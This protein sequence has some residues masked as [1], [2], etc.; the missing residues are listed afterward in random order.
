MKSRKKFKILI[1]T[2]AILMLLAFVKKNH[3]P[4]SNF[5]S[6]KIGSSD[7]YISLPYDLKP[8]SVNLPDETKEKLSI[9]E[10]FTF[11]RDKNFEGKISYLVW[12]PNVE[13]NFDVGNFAAIE[14][15]RN[16]P[17]VEK[18]DNKKEFFKKGQIDGCFFDAV[19]FRYGSSFKMRAANLNLGKESWGICITIIDTK[20]NYIADKIL[21]SL[22]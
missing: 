4:I 14:N 8:S 20:D 7:L 16:L 11:G 18:V 9:S 15:V 13:Y 17:G 21:N 19:I 10:F 12:R 1:A 2:V 5:K 22:R 3:D 6:V